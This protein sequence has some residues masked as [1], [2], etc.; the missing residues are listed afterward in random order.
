MTKGKEKILK[1]EVVG[2][3]GVV[4]SATYQWLKEM[5]APDILLTGRDLGDPLPED[6]GISFVCLPEKVVEKNCKQIAGYA[7]LIVVRSTVPPGTCRRIQEETGVHVSHI[8]EF[9][10][11]ATAVQDA[12]N[13]EY[14]LIGACCQEHGSLLK[15]IYKPA[16]RPVIVT[17]TITS[18][19]VKIVVNNY[20]A[21][22]VSFWNEIERIAQASGVSGHRIGAIA[23]NDSRVVS[24]GAR[25]HHRF[26]G[27]CLPKEL[28]QMLE[29]AGRLGLDTPML[30]AI[31][32]V[33]DCQTS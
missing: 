24:Y 20:L 13:P 8:P 4:G 28:D 14:I 29:Y 11:E 21:C 1:V 32:E 12:F 18:E 31:K 9:L 7:K 5:K 3:K 6:V 19:L 25:W 2:Y 16:Q 33:N 27:K 10:R 30:R 17:D 23:S 26:S 22:L 15:G